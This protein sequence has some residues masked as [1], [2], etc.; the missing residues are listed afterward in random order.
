MPS[1]L[2]AV[3]GM[4]DFK[5]G[6]SADIKKQLE[7]TAAKYPAFAGQQ[8]FGNGT[9]FVEVTYDNVAQSIV[10]GWKGS[11]ATLKAGVAAQKKVDPNWDPTPLYNFIAAGL[12]ADTSG[13]FW[14]TAIDPVFYRGC[15]DVRDDVRTTATRQIYDA[16]TTASAAA[17][18]AA[19]NVSI[20][21]HS[22]G[23][24]V[25]HDVL[26]QVATGAAGGNASFGAAQFAFKNLFMVA[27]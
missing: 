1:L 16:I 20:L 4:G 21:A 11:E 2:I 22:L 7:D 25:T 9:D 23:T 19:V 6:W 27:D 15:P 5:P 18:G 24:I 17:G 3:H 8:L 26:E 12:P 13:F 10:S 14:S